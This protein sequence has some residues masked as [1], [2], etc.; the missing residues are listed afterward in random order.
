MCHLKNNKIL[1]YSLNIIISFIII[2]LQFN[3]LKNNC[4]ENVL[5][6]ESVSREDQFINYVLNDFD[7]ISVME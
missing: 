4:K 6:E 2:V 5:A 3:A 1:F 7:N